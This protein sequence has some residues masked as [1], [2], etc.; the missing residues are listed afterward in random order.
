MSEVCSSYMNMIHAPYPL[1]VA[2]IAGVPFLRGHFCRFAC[3][4]L[5]EQW[6]RNGD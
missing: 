3:P 6:I 2:I 4:A 1:V 5:D